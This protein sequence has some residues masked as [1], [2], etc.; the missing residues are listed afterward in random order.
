MVIAANSQLIRY[1][2]HFANGGE[3]V[4]R[5]ACRLSLEGI[6]SKKLDSVYASGRSNS[7][8]KSKCRAGH[9]VVIGGWSTTNGQF[10]SLL[11]G[12][13]R[14]EHFA[15]I[16]PKSERDTTRRGQGEAAS[17]PAERGEGSHVA[18]FWRWCAQEERIQPSFGP[19]RNSLPKLNL[20]AGPG[21]AMSG[22]LPSRGFAKTSQQRMLKSSVLPMQRMLNWLNPQKRLGEPQRPLS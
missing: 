5:S 1:V 21:V 9:E 15:Y 22:R 11:V 14:G 13:N 8:A 4:L 7:W 10:R 20:P 12:V 2:E 3:A 17:P 16:R 18:F 6:V 19:G